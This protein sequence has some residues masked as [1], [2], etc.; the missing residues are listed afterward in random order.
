[1]KK[2]VVS[3]AAA[4]LVAAAPAAFAGPVTSGSGRI[5]MSFDTPSDFGEQTNRTFPVAFPETRV[6]EFNGQGEDDIGPRGIGRVDYALADTGDGATFRAAV[7]TENEGPPISDGSS[8]TFSL[9]FITD[10]ELRYEYRAT[11]NGGRIFGVSFDTFNATA[12]VDVFGNLSGD[13]PGPRD[14]NGN[15]QVSFVEI[16]RQGVLSPGTHTLGVDAIAGVEREATGSSGGSFSLE[17]TSS[18][19]GGPTPTPVPLPAAVWPGLVALGGL[20]G[21]IAARKRRAVMRP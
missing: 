20:F 12:E 13:W 6:V 5:D 8:S 2:L 17:L 9:S 18:D 16:V 14:P 15:T 21:T 10:R 4:A 19:N 1:M 11:T 7:T 3:L